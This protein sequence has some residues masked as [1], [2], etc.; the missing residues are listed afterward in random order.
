MQVQNAISA[1]RS[2]FEWKELTGEREPPFI[3]TAHDVM[4]CS[5]RVDT[6]TQVSHDEV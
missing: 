6:D 2:M 3:S 1:G 5:V 4:T